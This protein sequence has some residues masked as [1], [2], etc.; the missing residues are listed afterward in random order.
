MC[1]RDRYEPFA[2]SG[3]LLPQKCLASDESPRLVELYR[4]AETRFQRRIF[5]GYIVD[6]YKRQ[7]VP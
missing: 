2:Q 7:D 3:L 6:V 4:E 5:L 1:I